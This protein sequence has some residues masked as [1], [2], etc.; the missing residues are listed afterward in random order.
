MNPFVVYG[1]VAFIIAAGFL[2]MKYLDW[3][4]SNHNPTMPD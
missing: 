2:F 3:R 4:E 1:M